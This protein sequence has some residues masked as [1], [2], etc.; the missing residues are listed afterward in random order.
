MKPSRVEHDSCTS[1]TLIGLNG[2][3]VKTR[4]T[5]LFPSREAR[6]RPVEHLCLS[7]YCKNQ[8]QVIL[9]SQSSDRHERNLCEGRVLG[10]SMFLERTAWTRPRLSRRAVVQGLARRVW[11]RRAV[12]YAQQ[13]WRAPRVL[14]SNLRS[15]RNRDTT[16]TAAGQCRG[17]FG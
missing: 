14:G 16:R 4:G 10:S 8:D 2:T 13:P 5:T 9:R 6:D 12:R 17:S 3:A 15:K 11:A 7:D 1:I